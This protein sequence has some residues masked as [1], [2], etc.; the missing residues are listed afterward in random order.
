MSVIERMRNERHRE[1]LGIGM[2]VYVKKSMIWTR[3]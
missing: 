1:W 3:G 2:D